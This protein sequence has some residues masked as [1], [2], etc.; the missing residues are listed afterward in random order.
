MRIIPLIIL[1]LIVTSLSI[2]FLLTSNGRWRKKQRINSLPSKLLVSK[3]N[4]AII[5]VAVIAIAI[6]AGN[7]VSAQVTP[8]LASLKTVK[9]PEP[10]NLTD[11]VKNKVAAVKLGKALFWDMQVG[12]DGIT[13]CASCHFHAG[14][15]N[16]SKNQISPGLL[17]I[18]ADKT[19]NPDTVFDVGGAPNYQL[20]PED[21]PFHQ[22]SNP[23]DPTTVTSDR[24]DVVSSQGIFNSEFVD[25]KPGNAVD[26][27]NFSPDPV[28]NVG[29][30]NVRRVEPRNTPTVINSVFNFR[31][32]WDGRAQDIFNGV[33]PFGLRDPNAYVVKANTPSHLESVKVSLNHA[34]LASQAVGPPISSFEMSADGR[35][36]AE[37][38][39]KFGVVDKKS[40]SVGKGKK[41][42]RKLGKKLLGKDTALRPLG[43]QIV[44]P[45]DSVLGE[46]SRSPLPGL[47]TATYENLVADAF[48]PEWWRSNRIIQ[49]NPDGS[50]TFVKKPDN[51][52]QTNEYTLMEYNFPLFFGLAIQMYEST[53]IADD[54]P[55][56]RFLEGN[57]TALSAQQQRGKQLFEGKAQCT[58]CHNGA[59]LTRASVSAVQQ[60]RIGILTIPNFPRII[61]DEGFFN[62]GVRPTLEDVGV[63]SNDPF[64]NPL[65]ESR[66]SLLGTFKQLLGSDPNT[67]VTSNDLLI[68]DGSFKTPGLR[69]IEL[70]APY[71][72]SG[73]YL[74]LPQVVDF[75]SRGGDFRQQSALAQL[76]LTEDEKADLVAFLQ[77][78]T[79]ER[80]RYEKAPFDHPQL[81]VPNG[82]PGN[83]NSVTDDGTGKATDSFLEIPAVGEFGGNGTPNFLAQ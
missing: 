68:A 8:P 12:S 57:T 9:V 22:L 83:S 43:K 39:D 17:R 51:S 36:F 34:S 50:R 62:I 16:R 60:Q 37:I 59:E 40:H 77:S 76:N 3:F 47:Q 66:L 78:L 79:D 10:D 64:G 45:Q 61:F 80:V 24:N 67:T 13:A 33:N 7:T 30:T 75:Y 26:Q 11:F 20:K 29:G 31:N 23:N 42:L 49:V 69:N 38:G 52:L 32:F 41:L 72:H 21:F 14:A 18:N 25:V 70:T 73:G 63:G 2:Y 58:I 82:H 15:D 65:S 19:A 6:I 55:L 81:F 28:F 54:T 48:K 53:L 4:K 74:T 27:V 46:E 35:T 5:I 44:H 1:V 71:F 56:D